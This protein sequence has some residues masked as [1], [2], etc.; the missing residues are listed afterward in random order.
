[1]T[2]RVCKLSQQSCWDD[3]YRKRREQERRSLLYLMHQGQGRLS[4][5]YGGSV[6]TSPCS[7]VHQELD[8][9]GGNGHVVLPVGDVEE[10]GLI[11]GGLEDEERVGVSVRRGLVSSRGGL[12]SESFVTLLSRMSPVMAH[13]DRRVAGGAAPVYRDLELVNRTSSGR[14][15]A[16][17][18]QKVPY[19][20]MAGST[21]A[22]GFLPRLADSPSYETGQSAGGHMKGG[23]TVTSGKVDKTPVEVQEVVARAEVP[24]ERWHALGRRRLRLGTVRR[25]RLR[26]SPGL[27]TDPPHRA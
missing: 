13:G 7:D 19:R 15:Q 24:T 25:S 14:G 18:G 21:L 12:R 10:F 8:V 17:L 4:R 1:M 2:G 5:E 6:H 11:G 20:T 22:P 9:D 26:G 23:W 16:D 3:P 27:R